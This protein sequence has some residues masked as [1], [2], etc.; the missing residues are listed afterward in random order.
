[1]CIK[2]DLKGIGKKLPIPVCNRQLDLKPTR[3]KDS[4]QTHECMDLSKAMLTTDLINFSRVNVTTREL[5]A[6]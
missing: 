4:A 5:I 3:A 6:D 1:M 2:S